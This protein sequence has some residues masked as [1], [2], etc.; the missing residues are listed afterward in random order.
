VSDA[1]IFHQSMSGNAASDGKQDEER[2]PKWM[3]CRALMK[4]R[5]HGAWFTKGEENAV[6][7]QME[8]ETDSKENKYL[9]GAVELPTDRRLHGQLAVAYS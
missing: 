3:R 8:I 1:G 7:L 6:V 5:S 9:E 4:L 2:E